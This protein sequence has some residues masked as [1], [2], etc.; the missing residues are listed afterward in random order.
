VI[1]GARLYQ[2]DNGSHLRAFDT[3]SGKELWELTLGTAQKAAPVLADGKI[4]VGTDNGTFHIIR[5]GADRG[6]MLS[7][8][9]LPNSVNSCCG[10]EGTPEQILA[11]AAVS[12]G[13]I[14]FVS[15]DAVYAIG[16]KQ[17][18]AVTGLAVDEPASVGQG[19]PAHLQVAP[20]ELVLEPGQTV[21]LRARL[22]DDKGRFLREESSATWALDGLKGTLTNGSFTVAADPVEQ[23]GVITATVGTLTGQAR[24]RVVHSLPWKETFEGYADKAIPPG[25]VNA[26]AMAMSVTTLDGQK[27]LQKAPVDTIF[28]RGRAFI[29]PVT[30]SNYTFEADV[31]ASTRRRQIGDVG[32]TAQ[33]Y[34]LV[35]YGNSQRLKI[36]PW[37]PETARTMTVPFA[38]KPDTWYRLKLRVENL[39]N[40]QVRALGKAWPAG[41]P[42]PSAW[43]IEKLDPIGNRQGAPGFF[44]NAQ[45]GAY[46]DNLVLTRNP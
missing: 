37:E 33:R 23:A 21:R 19:N 45:F 17:A 27:V 46:Y 16:P 9:E 30:W 22:F 15:S 18:K 38:W 13:R 25:W 28:M 40:G 1:D 3:A 5:P 20:T 29:G 6:E 4:Y 24:A 32:I 12:R 26:Q 31:R 10:S 44:I 43:T 34:S 8:V 35:L 41:E 2:I 7:E 42:E 11:G 14:F 39:A 36:E